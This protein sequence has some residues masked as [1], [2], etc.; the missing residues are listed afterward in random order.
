MTVD[1]TRI[2]AAVMELLRAI[3]EDPSREGLTT[4]PA[5]VADAYE[6]FFAG[7]GADPVV[8]VAVRLA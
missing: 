4:T 7:I 6:E 8:I 5:R 1:K 3:G 2:E